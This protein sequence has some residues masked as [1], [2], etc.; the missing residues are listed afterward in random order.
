MDA[1]NENL[2]LLN[3]TE[4]VRKTNAEQPENDVQEVQAGEENI[5]T[6]Q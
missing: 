5:A 3:I 6:V 1:A 4:Q 2:N